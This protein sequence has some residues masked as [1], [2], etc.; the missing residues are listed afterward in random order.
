ML[1]LTGS[2]TMKWIWVPSEQRFGNS[3]VRDW[4]IPW[5][6]GRKIHFHNSLYLVKIQD[7]QLL[8]MLVQRPQII[9]HGNNISVI[10]TDALTMC[11]KI[12]KSQIL[13]TSS[14]IEPRQVQLHY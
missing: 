2:E 9:A 11:I 13:K 10:C 5:H 12:H 7:L 3:E 6:Y 8:I 1:L 14:E 4:I